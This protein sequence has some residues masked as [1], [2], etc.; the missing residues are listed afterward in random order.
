MCL[1]GLFDYCQVVFEL[2]WCLPKIGI[3]FKRTMQKTKGKMA[4]MRH[5][6]EAANNIYVD[7]MCTEISPG[8]AIAFMSF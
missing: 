7:N 3:T 5:A 1:I 6:F 4:R 8:A 2:P